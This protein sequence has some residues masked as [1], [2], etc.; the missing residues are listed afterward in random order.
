[1]QAYFSMYIREATV[2]IDTYTHT[3][4]PQDSRLDGEAETRSRTFR[5]AKEE[6]RSGQ[7]DRADFRVAQC[8][9]V[10]VSTRAS[11]AI[12]ASNG[13]ISNRCALTDLERGKQ[14][15]DR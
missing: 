12:P 3:V 9:G 5:W 14:P 6:A 4:T 7:H 13:E 11:G 8:E 10:Q 1:M 2:P 15:A